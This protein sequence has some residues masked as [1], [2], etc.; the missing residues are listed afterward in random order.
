MPFFH[1]F[2]KFSVKVAWK[3]VMNPAR[4][5]PF[6]FITRPAA[7]PDAYPDWLGMSFVCAK[8]FVCT[9]PSPPA[10]YQSVFLHTG[11]DATG[12]ASFSVLAAIALMSGL[13]RQRLG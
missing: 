11:S 3:P 2:R 8:Y 4:V 13:R 1:A 9:T 6:S 10:T 7:T 12:I 5:T